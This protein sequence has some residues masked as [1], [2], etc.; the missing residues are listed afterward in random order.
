M[1]RK[2]FMACATLIVSAAAVLGVKAYNYYSMSPLMRANLDALTSPEGAVTTW[3]CVGSFRH[4]SASC[5][6]CGT[7]VQGKGKLTGMHRCE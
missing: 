3:I 1:K 6:V 5:G 4:C 7:T 2:L